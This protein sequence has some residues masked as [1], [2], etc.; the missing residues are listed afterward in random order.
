MSDALPWE[1]P[2]GSRVLDQQQTE[3][4]V[5]AP[6]ASTL[7]LL[8][9][10][11]RLELED[12]GLGVHEVVTTAVAGDDYWYEVDGV[13]L[14]DPCSRWQP[15]GLRGPSRVVMPVANTLRRRPPGE[16]IIYELHVGTFSAEGT[17]DSAIPHLAALASLGVSAIEVMPVGEFPGARGWGYDG[18]YISAPQ[19]SYG[20]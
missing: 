17:F 6:S 7:A 10:G 18:V 12:A 3:F 8:V 16:L 19:S 15:E 14:P 9:A 5:W 20:G 13:K 11:R 2:L 1:L 4:R